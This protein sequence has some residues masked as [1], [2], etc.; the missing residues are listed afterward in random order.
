MRCRIGARMPRPARDP[1][2][3]AAMPSASWIR[4]ILSGR[5]EA[6]AASSW[7]L[8][9]LSSTAG[10]AGGGVGTGRGRRWMAGGG[11]APAARNTRRHLAGSSA[12]F[13]RGTPQ[14]AA[15][16]QPSRWRTTDGGTHPGRPRRCGRGRSVQ[17]PCTWGSASTAARRPREPPPAR[18]PPV[19]LQGGGRSAGGNEGSLG[20]RRS[21]Q[22]GLSCP[23]WC[24]AGEC[25][26][27]RMQA[28]LLPLTC[29]TPP[30]THLCRHRR[31]AAVGPARRQ[32]H[33]ARAAHVDEHL[34]PLLVCRLN[35]EPA[36][37]VRF[38]GW[39]DRGGGGGGHAIRC[40]RGV[41]VAAVSATGIHTRRNRVLRKREA[42]CCCANPCSSPRLWKHLESVGGRRRR[43][44]AG[45][46]SLHQVLRE[47]V[48]IG[49]IIVT[50]IVRAEAGETQRARCVA[51]PACLKRRLP[52]RGTLLAL[53]LCQQL[54]GRAQARHGGTGEVE[55]LTGAPEAA[56][57]QTSCSV[58][59]AV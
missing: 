46:H 33:L 49:A 4:K 57:C 34:L 8:R 19:A 20:G 2:C 35:H 5:K 10:E 12:R 24:S 31:R 28:S 56:K 40:L 59:A 43:R 36:A 53:Q 47:G 50:R 9:M 44:R 6:Q 32:G 38:G 21:Q 58:Y 23:G 27:S 41:G 37:V 29:T 25:D 48:Q 45:L 42:L 55:A 15:C 7:V 51:A 54:R 16:L 22:R 11:A 39:C 30:S 14:P 1:T 26:T 52:S 17:R 18:P 3:C 13:C